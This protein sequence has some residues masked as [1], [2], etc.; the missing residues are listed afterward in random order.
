MLA[1]VKPFLRDFAGHDPTSQLYLDRRKAPTV[2]TS[3]GAVEEKL[4][5]LPIMKARPLAKARDYE[6]VTFD[7]LVRFHVR[8]NV[9]RKGRPACG[10]SP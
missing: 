1:P 4:V 7:E 3:A 10:T 9:R 2:C 6:L 8:P 5:D